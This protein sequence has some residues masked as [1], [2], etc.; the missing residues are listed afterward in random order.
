MNQEFVFERIL[1]HAIF[2]PVSHQQQLTKNEKATKT[3]RKS[4]TENTNVFVGSLCRISLDKIVGTI[5]QH[6]IC[7]KLHFN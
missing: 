4:M 3:G 6:A 1:R 2:G 7:F 5:F